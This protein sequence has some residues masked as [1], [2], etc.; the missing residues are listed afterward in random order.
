MSIRILAPVAV[1]MVVASCSPRSPKMQT[2]ET[3]KGGTYFSIKQFID[4]QWRVY[5]G[6]PFGFMKY[7]YEDGK[8]DSSLTNIDDMNWGVI[9]QPFF[10]SDISDPRFLGHYNFSQFEDNATQTVNYYYEAKED[11]L[12]TRKLQI[13]A[14]DVTSKVRSIYIETEKNT[15]LKHVTHKLFYIPLEV[16]S[17][18]ELDHSGPSAK[19]L[20]IEYRFLH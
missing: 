6:Q 1:L 9:L 2:P 11:S 5:R 10:E 7:V 13:M 8:V 15:H 14:D 17:L 4:D 18:Q 16:I 12:F 20:R 19:E 3:A